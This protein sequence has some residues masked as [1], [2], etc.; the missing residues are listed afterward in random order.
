MIG[1]QVGRV[2]I[3]A[4]ICALGPFGVL[5]AIIV[6]DTLDNT[7]PPK[8]VQ[9]AKGMAT[10]TPSGDQPTIDSTLD[11][12]PSFR[13]PSLPEVRRAQRKAPVSRIY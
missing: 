13:T 12:R 6:V 4:A 5:G 10:N 2:F 11:V 1:R 8:R 9:A 7:V 3:F